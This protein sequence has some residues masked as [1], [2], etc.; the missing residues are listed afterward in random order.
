MVRVQVHKCFVL[1]S[2]LAKK[3]HFYSSF[4]FFNF[5][6]LI[7]FFLFR[8]YSFVYKSVWAAN[9]FF[10]NFFVSIFSTGKNEEKVAT[11]TA[12]AE[13]KKKFNLLKF[14]LAQIGPSSHRSECENFSFFPYHHCS[15]TKTYTS[16][17]LQIFQFTFYFTIFL[18][19]YFFVFFFI[20]YYIV[21]LFISRYLNYV[22]DNWNDVSARK[23]VPE[24]I[25]C[26]T[27]FVIRR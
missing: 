9:K 15:H 20:S 14:I 3:C 24:H 6:I 2:L 10:F 18:F 16:F 23:R 26:L 27:A 5:F 22:H 21:L 13:K 1:K 12:T 4:Y 8:S 7:F 17:V 11:A 25:K 19:L